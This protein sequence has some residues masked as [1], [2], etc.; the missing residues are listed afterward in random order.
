MEK[1]DKKLSSILSKVL[2]YSFLVFSNIVA[3]LINLFLSYLFQK[4]R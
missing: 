3:D 4:R 2:F 1:I